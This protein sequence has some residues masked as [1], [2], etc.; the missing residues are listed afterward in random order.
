MAIPLTAIHILRV[1]L[2]AEHNLSGLQRDM[3]SNANAWKK[4]VQAQS[5]PV[6]TIATWMNDAA[7]SYQSRLGWLDTLQANTVAWTK[8]SAMWNL[9]GGTN[10]DFSNLITPLRA[11]ADQLGPAAKTTYAQ[12]LG[13]CNYI[14][15]N[16]DAPLSLW[17]E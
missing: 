10:T 3:L 12:Q 8:L 2:Q 7:A 9:L 16:V 15:A 17:P 1:L 6:D 4:G 13:I 5:T 14:I 11:V